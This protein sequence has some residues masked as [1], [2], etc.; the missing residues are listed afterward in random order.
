MNGVK[1]KGKGKGKKGNGKSK[2]KLFEGKCFICL[3]KSHRAA[4]CKN[5]THPLVKAGKPGGQNKGFKGKGFT[6]K[7]KA[8]EKERTTLEH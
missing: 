4:E 3:E 1:G 2:G 7:A 8:R 6:S 5:E